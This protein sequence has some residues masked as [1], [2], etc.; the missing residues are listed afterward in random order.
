MAYEPILS[1][2]AIKRNAINDDNIVSIRKHRESNIQEITEEAENKI[3]Q[4]AEALEVTKNTA[5]FE[6]IKTI[7]M[8]DLLLGARTGQKSPYQD[9]YIH[10]M[11]MVD[12][13]IQKK[14]DILAKREAKKNG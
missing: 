10:L 3:I 4:L 5:G 12:K 8:D 2:S 7:V 11:D 6:A 1:S 14:Y 13:F 9:G